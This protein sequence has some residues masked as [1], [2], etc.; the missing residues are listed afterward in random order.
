MENNV[1]KTKPPIRGLSSP[2]HAS[3]ANANTQKSEKPLA[4]STDRVPSPKSSRSPRSLT[5]SKDNIAQLGVFRLTSETRLSFPRYTANWH[6]HVL[7]AHSVKNETD[8]QLR[9]RNIRSSFDPDTG[10]VTKP[11]CKWGENCYRRNPGHF[12]NYE[13]PWLDSKQNIESQEPNVEDL[14]NLLSQ[15]P[16]ASNG[17]PPDVSSQL[18]SHYA[19]TGGSPPKK[20]DRKAP[21]VRSE[22]FVINNTN[23][24]NY[25]Q[26]GESYA[27]KVASN[28]PAQS[29]P[30]T[31]AATGAYVST[32]NYTDSQPV[33]T[34]VDPIR[35]NIVLG[36]DAS[37]DAYESADAYSTSTPSTNARP[38]AN[39]VPISPT[40]INNPINSLHPPPSHLGTSPSR[41]TSVTI[42]KGDA[43]LF[44]GS[45]VLNVPSASPPLKQ[46]VISKSPPK[47]TVKEPKFPE[48]KK[49]AVNIV[50]L[51]RAVHELDADQLC[52]LLI[53]LAV[54]NGLE[55]GIMS[56]IKNEPKYNIRQSTNVGSAE[57]VLRWN[58]H[59]Q[60][61]IENIRKLSPNTRQE[62]RIKIYDQLATH[63]N[64]FIYTATTYGKIII[65][66]VFVPPEDKTIKPFITRGVAGGEKYLCKGI[67]FKFAVNSMNIYPDDEA[68]IKVAGHEL[69]ALNQVFSL[70]LKDFCFP[71]MILLDYRGFRLIAMST[72]PINNNTLVYGSGDAGATISADNVSIHNKMEVLGK[73]LNLKEH[74][75]GSKYVKKKLWTPVDLEVHYGFDKR[76][77]LL[78]F[79]RTFPPEKPDGG[80]GSYLY[81]LLRP[82]LV[83]KYEKPLCSDSYS[84]FIADHN[85]KEHNDEVDAATNF[86]KTKI[87]PEFAKVLAG[88]NPHDP[89]FSLVQNLHCYGINLRYVGIVRSHMTC[90]IPRENEWRFLLLI[91]MLARLIKQKI[92]HKLRE[93][94]K[95]LKQTGEQPYKRV[96]IRILNK[97]FGEGST[98][99][100]QDL[101]EKILGKF[102]GAFSQVESSE[103]FKLKEA[104]ITSIEGFPDGRCLLFRTVAQAAGLVFSQVAT[105]AFSENPKVFDFQNPFDETDLECLTV[106]VKQM[107][108]AQYSEGF[109]LRLKASKRTGEESI[110]LN[111]LAIEKFQAA[112]EA[113]PGN[114]V[115]L[116]NLADSCV[117]LG[118][119]E[120]ALSYYQRAILAD[121]RDTNT[122]F[123]YACFLEKHEKYDEAEEYYLKSLEED[124]HHSNCLC[125]YAD[126]LSSCRKNYDEAEYFYRCSIAADQKNP[127]ALNNYACFLTLVRKNLARAEK[128]FKAALEADPENQPQHWYNYALF[129]GKSS[130]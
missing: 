80:K 94:M 121:P 35:T 39:P 110:R 98:F 113:N 120:M 73:R 63:N 57:T 99:W 117:D 116:R 60:Q 23:G 66:E 123:K 24:A 27:S 82:E 25:I 67:Y 129:L 115:T 125:I 28:V 13:H 29:T 40:R 88:S 42:P 96:V 17:S 9:R 3:T 79:S 65:S 44:K 76:L 37:A 1:W 70:W 97:I 14:R 111:K 118:D 114:R 56:R 81:K 71:M 46:P 61:C 106:R 21:Y 32:N 90:D 83:R 89:S 34:S 16:I 119:M 104:L 33:I 112:L 55:D 92:R 108:I 52:D 84:N 45:Y 53:D 7:E 91:E 6:A 54:D 59:F 22:G 30:S 38:I 47:W 41:S 31:S 50:N 86:L 107:N 100:D 75:V 78:D 72:L 103:D 5:S 36:R 69:A 20:L 2:P 105:T 18:A 62:E 58:E 77:Y 127:F 49:P 128:Y 64:D 124:P 95:K 4:K 101:K 130:S 51:K 102:E 26:G 109:V 15:L 10:S 93:Q 12:K 74:Q 122:L 48:P 11:I 8:I 126:F 85:P 19:Y 43:Y 68:A 87:I